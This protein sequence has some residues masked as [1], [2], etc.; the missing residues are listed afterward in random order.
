MS[1]NIQTFNNLSV[2]KLTDHMLDD[3]NSHAV[4][5]QLFSLVDD[6]GRHKL[7][8]DFHDV[9]FIPSIGLAKLIALH[10]KVKGAGG[11]S[12]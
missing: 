6:Q 2:V 12:P 9:K 10:K 5:K 4:A 11:F 7:H 1:L 3:A 8:L